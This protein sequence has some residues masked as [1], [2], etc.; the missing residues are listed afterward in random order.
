MNRRAEEF[1][2][3]KKATTADVLK[4]NQ[5]SILSIVVALAGK[6]KALNQTLDQMNTLV[7]IVDWR[8]RALVSVLN[9]KKITL[10]D[11][12]SHRAEQFQI[13]DFELASDEEDKGKNLVA[14]ASPAETG[15]YA[16][17][18]VSFFNKGIDLPL[19]RIVRSKILIGSGS[20]FK[21]VDEALVGMKIGESK[22]FPLSLQGQTDQAEVTL[23][24]LRK[25]SDTVNDVSEQG[26]S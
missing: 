15:M 8:S 13:I 9:E 19:E 6:L 17:V 5:G 20:L 10:P 23:I 26:N 24:G 12:I 2:K 4:S 16:I 14:V 22:K 21:E 25:P 3:N 7:T 11:E 18:R 1:R